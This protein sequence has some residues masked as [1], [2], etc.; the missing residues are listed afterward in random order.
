MQLVDP[1]LEYI[2]AG[3]KLFYITFIDTIR[4]GINAGTKVITTNN[5]DKFYVNKTLHDKYPINKDNIV[6]DINL[7]RFLITRIEKYIQYNEYKLEHDKKLLE[8]IRK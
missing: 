4:D 6:D 5:N 8:Q 2:K 3:G 1:T 7:T